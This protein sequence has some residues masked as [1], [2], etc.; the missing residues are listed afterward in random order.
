MWDALFADETER[1]LAHRAA[2]PPEPKPPKVSA[3]AQA[4]EIAASPFKGL[5]QG[6]MQTA[7]VANTVAPS[8][9]G[10]PMA[11]TAA[12]QEEMLAD[13]SITRQAMDRDLRRGVQSLRPDPATSTVAS[14]FLQEG[15]RVLGKVAGYAVMAGPVGAVVGTGIDEGVTGAQELMDR[16]VDPKTAAKAGAVRGAAVGLSVA[17][18]AVG[19]TALRT[20]ALVAAGGPGAFVAEQA[21]TRQ[22]LEN[23]RYDDIA[24]EYDPLDP[25]GLALSA[26]VPGAVGVALHRARGRRGKQS[27]I[28]DMAQ[29]PDLVDAALVSHRTQTVTER[30]LGDITQPEVA[31]SHTKALDDAARALDEGAPVQALDVTVDPVR[32]AEVIGDMQQRLRGVV[33]QL[34]HVDDGAP[35]RA[36]FVPRGEDWNLPGGLDISQV[37]ENARHLLGTGR[38]AVEALEELQRG[39]Q[40]SPLMASAMSAV[41]QHPKRIPEL[42]EQYRAIDAN[43]GGLVQPIEMLADAYDRLSRALPPEVPNRP[44]ARAEMVA[45]EHPTLL[46]RMDDGD[47]PMRAEDTVN[48]A[49]LAAKQDL[50]DSK[51]F[52]AAVECMLRVGS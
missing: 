25:L 31:N 7:R 30:A 23:A 15:A 42:V 26:V 45:R 1:A 39:G 35:V 13:S 36:D 22:I 49:R 16:G 11:M 27:P 24:Q 28:E 20:A 9:V 29:D 8:V 18:P 47:R 46:V 32:A 10:N 34:D 5:A 50:A 33:D 6:G 43:R 44:L 4:G 21:I 51:A 41:E 38:T 19:T 52:E 37:M 2:N 17:L 48:Q 12:E 14:Q 40:V 3:W